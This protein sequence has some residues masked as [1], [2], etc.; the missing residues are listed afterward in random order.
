VP[1]K[2]TEVSDPA[3]TLVAVEFNGYTFSFIRDQDDW[4][5][6]SVI[7]AAEGK[8]VRV[9]ELVLG[10]KQWEL[11]TTVAAPSKRQFLEFVA[12]FSTA[13]E[14]ECINN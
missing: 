3:D 13:V 9:V 12:L 10:E 2:E 5:T 14:R 8:F 7:A 4:P 11:L 1:K 6:L